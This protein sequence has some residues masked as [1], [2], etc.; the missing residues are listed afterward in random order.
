M[1]DSSSTLARP[2]SPLRRLIPRLQPHRYALAA[3]A[4]ALVAS[5]AIGLAFPLVVRYLMDAAFEVRDPEMLDR[6]AIFLIGLFGIQAVLNFVQV[7]LLGATAERV[8]AGLRTDLYS[9]LLTLSPGFFTNRNSGELTAR[10]ASD[11]STLGT[12]LSHQVAEFFRQVLFLFGGL[13]LLAVL[14][15]RL[16]LTT[17][18]VAP[19]VVLSAY[20]FGQI[21]RKQ[22]TKVQDRLAQANAAAE[23]ALT[24]IPV[25]QSFVREGWEEQRYGSRIQSALREAVGRS[26]V[27]GVFFGL[28]TFIAFGGVAVVLWEGG[29]L[30]IAQEITAGELVSFLLYAV[31]VAAAITALASLW[32]GYQEAMGAA[33]RVFDLMDTEPEIMEPRHSEALPPASDPGGLAFHD[34]WFRYGQEEPWILR[35]LSVELKP[36]EAVALV[37]PSGAG[38][39]TIASLV[40][41][42]WDPTQGH[43]TLRGTDLR[44]IPLIELRTA[45][46]IVPQD[47]LLFADTV[48]ANI[49]YG[50]PEATA[51][52]I[53]RAARLAHAHEF[54]ERLA[55]GYDSQVGER[56]SRLSGGQ[57]QRIAIARIFLK[58]PEI[59]ILDE[60]TS[61]LDTESEQLVE[62][63][64]ESAMR[65]R[66]TLIIAHRLR[67]VQRADRVLVVDGGEILEQGRHAELA[68]ADGLYARLYRGQLLDPEPKFVEEAAVRPFED[69]TAG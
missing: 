64:L 10:L 49:A 25:V 1:I 27:R 58:E 62:Q 29:R 40:P 2:V 11:C 23:E 17:V 43:I 45:V 9:H 67:T 37:G 61:S 56:G 35:G 28:V 8:V 22:S 46:G 54:I 21:L 39:T 51:E 59:L 60:A 63:A 38:K 42:F 50:K 30:V 41:R 31:T 32:S 4:V 57:R 48:A 33:Q 65:G 68:S 44:R 24:Q 53:E 52:E 14:H 26:L 69:V 12:V 7:F 66:T 6:V 15:S 20:A 13:A 36:G 47:P 55:E 18:T 34:V 19:I 3:A 16:M 5:A